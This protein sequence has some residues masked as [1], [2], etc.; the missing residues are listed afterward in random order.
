MP[1]GALM[2]SGPDYDPNSTIRLAMVS[3]GPHSDPIYGSEAEFSVY[4]PSVG[5]TQAP[6][7]SSAF[8]AVQNGEP[9]T[10]SMIMVGW[11][12]NPQFYGD[13]HAHFEIVWVDKGKTCA[14][15]GCPG[16]VQ[17]SKQV[18]PGLKITPVSTV[19]GQ[20]SY[21][22]VKVFKDQK[23]G[24]WWLI[25]GDGH[26][27]VGYWPKELFTYMADAADVVSW[28]GMV[29]AARG[30]PTPPMGSGQS[31]DQGEGKAAYFEN[32]RVVDASHNLVVPSLGGCQTHVTEPSCY[33]LG[34]FTNSDDG[35][36][37]RFLYGGGGCHPE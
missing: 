8:L 32:I 17:Q 33:A 26:H 23:T 29:A 20:Q 19:G 5:E 4:E 27:P 24:N 3:T 35:S 14:N 25:Y 1:L 22:H 28:F 11:D 9:P 7:F 21:L 34:H 18:F 2:G 31:P 12:V 37:L 15:L 36:G 10:Y 16:F 13:D 6:R 30:E